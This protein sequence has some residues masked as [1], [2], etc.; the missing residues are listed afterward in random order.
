MGDGLYLCTGQNIILSLDPDNGEER[1]RFD[2]QIDTPQIGFWDTCR[3]VTHYEAPNFRSL[4]VCEERIFTATTDARLIAVNKATGERC[5]DF[6][7]NGEISL[8]PGM[9]DV[10]PGFYFVTSPP[11]I[12]ND[13][14]VLGG[15]VFDNVETD[16]PSG[17]VRGFD[18]ISG[19][20]LWAWDMGREDRVG[21]P[22]E[23][24]TYTRGTPNVWSLTSAD[25]ELGLIY[26][27][28]GN[29]TPDYYGGH[30][31][32]AMEKYSSSIVALEARTG[33]VRWHFQTTHHDI[34]DYDVPSQPSLV[35][36][37]IN[38]E[39]RKAVI[40]PTKRAE[41]FVFDRE[42]GEPLTEIAELPV[43]VSYTHLTLPTKRI[44]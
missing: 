37:P 8:L 42:T 13:V 28:T 41:I 3:G 38:G 35:D 40:V 36:I 22:P 31:S 20:L 7:D 23:G 44:V 26:L 14:L 2:P 5:D 15:W 24:D 21:L 33:R 11:T 39:V 6:G 10:K 17:V 4:G 19:D 9:G 32:E 43:P 12:A 27:P 30:R 18:P 34:F 1:W 16:E 25:E 29:A